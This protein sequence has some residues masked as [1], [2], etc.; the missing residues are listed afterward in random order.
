MSALVIVMLC[1]VIAIGAFAWF[2]LYSGTDAGP[3]VLDQKP[4]GG[5]E[6]LSLINF[7]TAG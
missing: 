2:L 4:G 7:P 1:A 3:K 6:S 5:G